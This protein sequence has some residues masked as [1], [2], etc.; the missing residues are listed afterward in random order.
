MFWI[1]LLMGGIFTTNQVL[2]LDIL[3]S[4]PIVIVVVTT[5]YFVSNQSTSEYRQ[6]WVQLITVDLGM[7]KKEILLILSAGLIVGTLKETGY[8]FILFN[9]FLTAVE[10]L[11]INILLSLT[12][13]VIL[14][15]FCGFPPIP[16]MILL[17][18]ILVNVPGG[19]PPELVALSLLLG[20]SVT[21]V[22]APVT[23]PLLLISS[24]NGRSL[25]EN[26]FSSNIFFAVS[27]L[28]VG[29]LYIQLLTVLS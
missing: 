2:Q 20:V 1:S 6:L 23:V 12:L 5:L 8:G 28:T 11:N 26:G 15:G 4:V 13:V 7:K 17:S 10:W 29:L 22:I 14:L 3:L 18:G 16:A 24:L 25:S 21:L 9:Y 19:Y 27:L